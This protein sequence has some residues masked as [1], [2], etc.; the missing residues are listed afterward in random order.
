MDY[1]KE[2]DKNNVGLKTT[3]KKIFKDVNKRLKSF[4]VDKEGE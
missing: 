3:L 1:G 4:E 2:L